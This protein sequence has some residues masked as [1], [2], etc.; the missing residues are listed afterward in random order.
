[1]YSLTE[2]AAFFYAGIII[3]GVAFLFEKMLCKCE[4]FSLPIKNFII[5]IAIYGE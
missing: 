2:Y 4:F 1:M 3:S 5:T